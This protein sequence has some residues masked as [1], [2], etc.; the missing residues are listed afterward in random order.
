[1]KR[2]VLICFSGFILVMILVFRIVIK[3][4]GYIRDMKK[5]I[6]NHYR[7]ISDKDIA[8]I[9]KYGNY[10]IVTTSNNVIVL[11]KEYKEVNKYNN[12]DLTEDALSNKLVY[13][14]DEAL[15]VTSKKLDSGL[16]YS[17]YNIKSG[18]MVKSLEVG[19]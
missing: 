9:S 7:G 11:D 8:S 10:Y 3:N 19:R 1:M 2:I 4:D 17:Y 15:F 5:S 12:E 13:M 16:M 14:D 18:E 6:V